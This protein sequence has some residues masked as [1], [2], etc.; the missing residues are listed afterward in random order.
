M[1]KEERKREKTRFVLVQKGPTRGSQASLNWL[2][3][4]QEESS[5]R[6]ANTAGSRQP[7]RAQRGGVP[8]ALPHNIPCS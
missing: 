7:W 4:P 8:R 3:A 1:R 6:V 2:S 5:G